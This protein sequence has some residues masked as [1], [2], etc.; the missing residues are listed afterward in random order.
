MEVLI[1]VVKGNFTGNKKT[2]GYSRLL[3]VNI[4]KEIRK[5]LDLKPPSKPSFKVFVDENSR[6]IILELRESID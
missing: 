4:P 3:A 1:G 6:R 5:I 2:K